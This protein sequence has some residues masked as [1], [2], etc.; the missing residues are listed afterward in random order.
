M[1]VIIL[2]IFFFT[3]FGCCLGNQNFLQTADIT[4]PMAPKEI[5]NFLKGFTAGFGLLNTTHAESCLVTDSQVYQDV[6]DIYNLIKN[7]KI[8]DL[9]KDIPIIFAKALDA[10]NIIGQKSENCKLYANELTA[11]LD[12]LKK[13]VTDR[14]YLMNLIIHTTTN[15][16][17][18]TQKVNQGQS[19]LKSKNF[20]EVGR[21]AGDLI[22][23]VFFWS[24]ASAPR[25]LQE[26]EILDESYLAL[27]DGVN[28]PAEFAQGFFKGFGLFN[29]LPHEKECVI[30]DITIANDVQ[31]LIN[32]IKSITL[33]TDFK[34]I[35]PQ[36]YV[37]LTEIYTKIGKVS[38]GC[39]AYANEI[40]SVV[41]AM[42]NYTKGI[43]YWANLA[44]HV[45]TNIGTINDKIKSGVNA[46][47][48]KNFSQSGEVFGQLIHFTFFW[49]FSPQPHV[50]LLDEVDAGDAYVASAEEVFQFFIGLNNG[51]GFLKDLPNFAACTNIDPT[52]F[53]DVKTV[54]NIIS[55]TPKDE[56]VNKIPTILMYGSVIAQKATNLAEPCV[57][58]GKELVPVIERLR[59]TFNRNF[60]ITVSS[61]VFFN[62]F[63]FANR[64]INI[65]NAWLKSDFNATGL[66]SG[67][68]IRYLLFWNY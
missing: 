30:D 19:A 51:F 26:I 25:H 33:K 17:A 50:A 45:A 7:I 68:F 24:D 59:N 48:A 27:V 34:K 21:I 12:K 52:I 63:D 9:Q 22:H 28:V 3:I 61:R 2:S 36:I 49:D 38:A 18:I 60:N 15:L 40:K 65:V 43:K 44:I 66:H 39:A 6:L 32:I 53:D 1:K 5:D 58:Y 10:I 35:I 37:K 54:F 31:D 62:I 41:D 16:G 14:S 13:T 23:F 20:F 46:Y 67:T 56:V 55:T 29:N 8:N 42:K 47:T 57:N 11:V 64:V 4:D